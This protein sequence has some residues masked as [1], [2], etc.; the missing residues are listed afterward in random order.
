[1]RDRFSFP[2]FHKMPLIGILRGYSGDQVHNILQAGYQ[3]G[4][5][6]FEITMNTEGVTKMIAA[7][8]RRY[9]G[10]M[11]IGAGTVCTPEDLEMALTAG[12]QFIV[13][14]ILDEEVIGLCKARSIPIFCGALTPTEIYRAW[15]LGADMVK[16]FPAELHGPAYLKSVLAPL[17]RIS[18]VPTGGVGLHNMKE[19]WDYGA[20]GFGMGSQ[21]LDKELIRQENWAGLE[22][23]FGR[24][25][26]H[27]H[28]MSES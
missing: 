17:N 13:T 2:L 12:A 20:K 24:L 25:C 14:P 1:M 16:L 27:F 28:K 3:A 5:T 9:A 22:N 6:T 11:N 23:H 7:A 15:S 4:L 8:A 19:Y 21:L 18:I 10:K 26:A